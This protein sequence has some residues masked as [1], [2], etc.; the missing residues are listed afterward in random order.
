MYDGDT[1]F[2]IATGERDGA[3]VTTIG[4]LA[5]DT[6]AEAIIRAVTMAKSIPGYPAARDVN[7]DPRQVTVGPAGARLSPPEYSVRVIS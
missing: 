7:V 2:A 1:V 6:I 4:A 5:A 3:D